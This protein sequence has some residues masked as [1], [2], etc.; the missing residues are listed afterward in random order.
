MFSQAMFVGFVATDP[1][2]SVLKFRTV[3][4]YCLECSDAELSC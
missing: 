3:C 1:E 4:I 2:G